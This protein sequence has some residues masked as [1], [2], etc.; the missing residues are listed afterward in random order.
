MGP[1]E[2]PA[3]VPYDAFISYS[4]QDIAFARQLEK[5]LEGYK[6]PRDLHAPQRYLQVFRDEG[7]MTGVE[8]S[9]S[10]DH[11]LHDS[12]KLIVICSP[13]ARQSQYVNDEIRRFARARGAENIIPLLLAGI[14]NN[15]AKPEQAAQ[16]AFPEALCDVLGMPLAISYLGF[17]PGQDQVNKGAFNSSWYNLLA[18]LYNLS[19]GE[20]EQRDLK[21]R[22]RRRNIVFT[23]V[24]L[25]MIS[26][27]GLATYAWRQKTVAETRGRIA[28]SRQLAA[29]ASLIQTQDAKLLDR[30]VLLAVESLRRWPSATGLQALS[31]GLA[32][33]PAM[34][35]RFVH[36]EPV[37]TL[38]FS[39]DGRWLATGSVNGN[40]RIWEI[41]S[42]REL[43]KATNKIK[44]HTRV[45]FSPDG[46]FLAM[47][48][49]DCSVRLWQAK[50]GQ[51]VTLAS[52]TLDSGISSIAF[53]PDGSWLAAGSHDG[54]AGVWETATG[55]MVSH[56]VSSR[57]DFG[58]PDVRHIAF[59]PNGRWLA[60]A[61]SD[62][63][64][65]VWEAATGRLV[66]EMVHRDGDRSNSAVNC[67]AFSPKGRWLATAGDD[68]TARIWEVVSGREMVRIKHDFEV[69]S[70]AFSPD[71]LF[72][73]TGTY[74]GTAHIFLAMIAGRYAGQTWGKVG[75]E[76]LWLT[77]TR[78]AFSPDSKYLAT[79]R[80]S[81]DT[82]SLWEVPVGGRVEKD[83]S[84]LVGRE[85]FRMTHGKEVTQVAFSP[86]GHR[87]AT[88]SSDGTA[89]LWEISPSLEL[90]RLS[91][92]KEAACAA[93]DP[94]GKWLATGSKDKI[95]R[96]WEAA[97]G[98]EAAAWQHKDAVEIVAFSPEGNYLA[99]A[100]KDGSVAL[101]EVGS[102][103]AMILQKETA[104]LGAL[105]FSPDGKWLVTADHKRAQIFETAT[106]RK[107]AILSEAQGV[108]TLTFSADGRLLAL[109]GSKG[110]KTWELASGRE[111]TPKAERGSTEGFNPPY[112]AASSGREVSLWE[113][114]T[115]RQVVNF[116]HD[117][118]V[119][120][121][122]LSPDGRWLATG[123]ADRSARLWD[124]ASGCEMARMKHD[125]FVR[126][127]AFSPDSKWLATGSD[128]NTA[129]IWAVPS[130][131]EV[132]RLAHRDRVESVIFS[133][134]GRWLTTVGGMH[135]AIRTW[136]WQPGD[137]INK[138]C[139]CLNRNLT[140]Q[141]WR[142][143]MGDDEPYRKTCPSLP[144]PENTKQSETRS[145]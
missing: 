92:L 121:V 97:T 145:E 53:S 43:F 34:A 103:R 90:A 71:G 5:V 25:V 61:H 29:Q 87:V 70:V 10:I 99:A 17:D 30:S 107:T 39:P 65:K 141:E 33:L 73:G 96:L 76:S 2:P 94:K 13:A 64:A 101:W 88:A 77:E 57:N 114:A 31:R 132:A 9:Q 24:S 126:T 134:D 142:Q 143:Y 127:I 111:V 144:V 85:M 35:K 28:L 66:T 86:G 48:S 22:L 69:K 84:V 12:A 124:I 91:H 4:R 27:A 81:D 110:P 15:E 98:R 18:N 46:R 139:V 50:T 58:F 75:L 56:L 122:A 63:S 106:G 16:T 95:V 32:L 54:T 6:P 41:A 45:L 140:R 82:A 115:G 52:H 14:P 26:L 3:S 21:R 8:Y 105:A 83:N 93:Y 40:V 119:R 130:G 38:A 47:G 72:L 120:T 136:I 60:T 116:Y 131:Q 113:A 19:R 1:T 78:V 102:G 74:G 137:L 125:D 135:G 23:I 109:A 104:Q 20:I 79:W 44:A 37:Y 123:S 89:V 55:S 49:L 67:V 7:D 51:E 112:L 80:T 62:S 128:D 133:P 138:A 129:R 42:N 118:R 108:Q 36:Q 11:H 117:G 100:G 68:N 59:S